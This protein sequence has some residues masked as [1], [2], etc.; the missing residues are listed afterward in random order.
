M[1]TKVISLFLLFSTLYLSSIVGCQ[2]CNDIQTYFKVL[3]LFVKNATKTDTNR[4]GFTEVDANTT[5]SYQ[6]YY[7]VLTVGV[8]YFSDASNYFSNPFMGTAYACDSPDPLAA[9]KI[10]EL[11]VYSNAD[12]RLTGDVV[13]PA[14]S[15]LNEYFGVDLE[16]DNITTIS[17]FVKSDLSHPTEEIL[18]LYLNQAPSVNQMHQF[19]VYYELD[20]GN[21][22]SEKTSNIILSQ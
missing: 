9:E 15:S 8:E 12:L 2:K 5:V 17:D 3:D 6:D 21:V 20:S 4:L 14:G 18:F 11:T 22:Y 16:G 19:N 10:T 7:I 1:R 13:I